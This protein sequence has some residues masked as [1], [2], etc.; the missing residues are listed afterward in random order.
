MTYSWEKESLQ[1]YGEETTSK[2]IKQQQVKR[3]WGQ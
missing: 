1:K 2:L 3:L